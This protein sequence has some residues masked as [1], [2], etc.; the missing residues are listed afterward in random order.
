[1]NLQVTMMLRK[2]GGRLANPHKF[3]EVLDSLFDQANV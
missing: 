3:R 2:V 1:M